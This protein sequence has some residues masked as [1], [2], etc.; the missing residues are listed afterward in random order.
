MKGKKSI[1]VFLILALSLLLLVSGCKTKQSSGSDNTDR[2]RPTD[3]FYDLQPISHVDVGDINVAYKVFGSGDPLV[4]ITGY[5]TTMDTWDPQFL[6]ALASQYQVIVFDNRGMGETTGGTADWTIDQFGTDT[7]GLI[8]AL[9]WNKANVL[10]WSIGGD[11][12]LSVVL[13]HP[14]SVI[15][16]VSYAGDCGGTQ[17][18]P[19]PEYKSVLQDIQN[20]DV[21]AKNVLAALFPGWYMEANPDY[22]K[23]FP[24]PNERTGLDNI[25]KQNQAYETWPGVYD[26]LPDINRPVLVAT[27]TLD[28]STPPQNAQILAQR[29][30]GVKVVEFE[31]GAHGLQYMYPYDFAY[32]IMQFLSSS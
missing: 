19:A 14:D 8:K 24:W 10:G 5:S 12:A 32:A 18:I 2:P 4:L 6:Q 7:A 22:W 25:Q 11:I 16:L 1:V 9:G 20:V 31:G 17:K 29:I 27:G 23:Q 28:A 26:K 13:N 30:P 15:K 21:P 3:T